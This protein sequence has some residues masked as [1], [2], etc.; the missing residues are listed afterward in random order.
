MRFGRL[1]GLNAIAR[2]VVVVA[3]GVV[4]CVGTARGQDV[5]PVLRSEHGANGAA[6]QNAH[7]VIL[8][9]LD[10]FRYDYAEKY[11]AEHI[12]ALGAAGASAPEGMIPAY[13]SLT[14]ANHYTLAT[15]L[16]PEHHGIVANNFYDPLRQRAYHM[17]DASAVADGSWYGGTPIWVLA[18]Q[19]GMRAACFFWP[20]SEAEIQGTRPSYYLKYDEKIHDDLRV[21]QVLA[22]LRLPAEQRP[23]LI[24]LYFSG[25]DH[26]GHEH[27]PESE[28]VRS[29]VQAVDKEVGDLMEGVA[30]TKLPVDVIVLSDHGM[31]KVQ[32][33]WITLDEYF[34]DADASVHFI[35]PGLYAKSDAD[36]ERVYEALHG[37][38]DKFEVYRRAQMPPGL[39][40]DSNPRSGDPIVVTTGPYLVRFSAK[41]RQAAAAGASS[42]SVST[43][44]S[45]IMAPERRQ[46][47][48]HGYD[49]A[50]V[51]EMKASFFAAGPDIRS[52]VTVA[53]FENVNVYPLVAKLLGLDIANLK[54]GAID[55]DLQVLQMILKTPQDEKRKSARNVNAEHTAPY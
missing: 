10:G 45:T 37:K 30:K 21:A 43:S 35:S 14:F 54:T 46:V 27:G 49:P 25:V 41:G 6:Q 33:D 52:G 16:Y 3:V 55:G 7:Y 13:P 42:A 44:G 17:T 39:H 9:S 36:A 32:G 51:P 8:V 53:P 26:A 1:D 34:P 19:Q 18:E 20:G 48:A 29:A 40:D 5:T 47:G 38:S 50:R 31:A 12:R 24:T 22:W 4:C 11:H 28:E 2:L 15:G 23:H